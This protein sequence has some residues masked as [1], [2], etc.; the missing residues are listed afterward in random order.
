MT[1]P[2]AAPSWVEMSSRLR[3]IHYPLLGNRFPIPLPLEQD[4]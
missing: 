4:E 1:N 2:R 3:V